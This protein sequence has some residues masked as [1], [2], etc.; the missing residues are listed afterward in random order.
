M[1]RA[2]RLSEEAFNA[3]QLRVKKPQSPIPPSVATLTTKH[4]DG[5]A[6]PSKYKNVKH[7]LDGIVFDSKR[8]MKRWCALQ[9]LEAAG[10]IQNLQRQVRYEL[11][12]PQYEN[13]KCVERA[14]NYVADFNY[15]QGG[16]E[17]VEDAKGFVTPMYVLK[18]K[19]MRHVH[20]IAVIES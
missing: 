17:V 4:G 16:A 3:H 9:Q 2:I 8:E 18:R 11:I 12:P 19:L 6:R 10:E 13:G 5:G 15:W 7:E 14:V 20:G 1:S